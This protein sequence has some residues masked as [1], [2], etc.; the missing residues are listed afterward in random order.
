M[1]LTDMGNLASTHLPI[2]ERASG[3]ARCNWVCGGIRFHK[4][5]EGMHG[6]PSSYL[7]AGAFFRKRDVLAGHKP[8]LAPSWP[9]HPDLFPELYFG[10][11][12]LC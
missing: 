8:A 2:W 12:L 10:T 6:F 11:H 5:E 4:A 3:S 7:R 1:E 9:L